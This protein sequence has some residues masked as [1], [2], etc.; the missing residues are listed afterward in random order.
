MNTESRPFGLPGPRRVLKKPKG[1]GE[2]GK[3]FCEDKRIGFLRTRKKFGEYRSASRSLFNSSPPDL[4]NLQ[5]SKNRYQSTT[6]FK[7][8]KPRRCCGL[9]FWTLPSSSLIV[10]DKVTFLDPGPPPPAGSRLPC[11]LSPNLDPPNW[12]ACK[13]PLS[14]NA[15]VRESSGLSAC[16]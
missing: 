9:Y 11:L 3:L 4:C 2:E 15:Y 5:D 16:R 12:D 8:V 13:S 14:S 6:C 1:R 10:F 7:I